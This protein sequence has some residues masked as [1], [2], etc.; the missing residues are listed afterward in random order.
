MLVPIIIMITAAILFIF[1]FITSGIYLPKQLG[2]LLKLTDGF[3]TPPDMEEE[4]LSQNEFE[5]L[6]QAFSRMAGQQTELK[7]TID[8][9]SPD[10]LSRLFLDLL[11]GVQKSQE[12]TKKALTGSQFL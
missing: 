7:T 5:H 11:S 1:L 10:I 4:G 3:N 2:R 9:I 8:D 12:D 6:N